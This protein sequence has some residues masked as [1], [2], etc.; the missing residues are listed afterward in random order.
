MKWLSLFASSRRRTQNRTRLLVEALEDRCVPA[1]LHV[2]A[3]EQ[4][5]TIAAAAAAAQSGDDVQIDAGTYTGTGIIAD[6]TQSNITIEGV[7]G[8][9]ILDNINPTTGQD[10]AIGNR[11]GIFVIDGN[12]VTVKNITFENAHDINGLDD[13]WA[14]IRGEGNTLTLVNC[15]FFHN[16]DGIL[17]A[18]DANFA[19]DNNDLTV[20]GCEFAYNGYGDGQSHNMYIGEISAFTLEYSYSHDANQGHLVKSRALTTYLLYNDFADGPTGGGSSE[21][22]IPYGGT[23]YLVG[24]IIEKD[25]TAANHNFVTFNTETGPAAYAQQL[26]VVNNTFVNDYGGGTYVFGN[27]SAPPSTLLLENNI[28]AGGGSLASVAY[29]SVTNLI[30]NSPGFMSW[31]D[32]TA[33]GNYQLAPGSPAINAGTNPGSVNGFSL[34]PTEEYLAP[35]SSQARP[36][37]GKLDVGA[38]EYVAAASPPTVATPASATP[39]PVTGT[40]TALS[41]LGADAAGETSLTYTWTASGPATVSYSANG[42]NAA[43]NSTAT[44]ST[45]GS[46]VFTVKITDKAGLSTT[47]TV[48]VTVSQTLT[49]ITVSPTAAT[50]GINQTEKFTATALDQF[51]H[52][53]A[54]QPAFTWSLASG[55]VGSINSTGLYQAPS[56]KGGSATVKASAGGLSATATVTVQFTKPATPSNLVAK[57]ANSLVDLTWLDASDQAGFHVQRSTNGTSWT[58]IATVGAGVTS[59]ST[60]APAAGKTYYYRVIAYNAAGSSAASSVV[61]VKGA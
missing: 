35:L 43:K 18:N 47:S 48:N 30:S 22:D 21:I 45:A 36:S 50:I 19:T 32:G 8:R 7:G 12:N 38:Y 27:A 23:A 1:V 61:V 49:K 41:V 11:K 31:T 39:N 28:F 25:A 29:T 60:T 58:T 13:N 5:T 37:D 56:G 54:T 4:Y 33:G 16:D 10:Q 2:G 51:G 53:L 14:G 44:F 42:T 34:V 59:Y 3:T 6:W 17:I 57:V 24:N 55:S 46:Y 26:Y 15:S 20:N 9:V 52:A 40:T